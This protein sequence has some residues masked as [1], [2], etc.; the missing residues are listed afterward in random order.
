MARG[1]GED[2][3]VAADLEGLVEA[4]AEVAR[5]ARV[6]QARGPPGEREGG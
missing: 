4:M 6:G 5:A 2:T 3:L 1:R